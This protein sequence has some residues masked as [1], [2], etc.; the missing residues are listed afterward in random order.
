MKNLF[1]LWFLLFGYMIPVPL[2]AESLAVVAI[3]DTQQDTSVP[4]D[5]GINWT[6]VII[7]G[8]IGGIVILAGLSVYLCLKFGPGEGCCNGG[9]TVREIS[10]PLTFQKL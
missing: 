2:K 10:T 9:S 8:S 6:P 7:G 3:Q 5:S 4:T 1:V